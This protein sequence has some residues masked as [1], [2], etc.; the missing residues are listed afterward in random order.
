VTPRALVPLAAL[1][2][3]ACASAPVATVPIDPEHIPISYGGGGAVHAAFRISPG[4]W[5]DLVELFGSCTDGTSE[6]RAVREAIGRVERI[7]GQQTITWMDKSCNGNGGPT[8]QGQMD[9]IDESSN[10][11]GY[12]RLFEQRGLLRFHRVLRPVWR[13]PRLIDTHRT[14]VI[15]DTADGKR[16]AVDSWFGDNGVPARTQALED[17]TR[18]VPFPSD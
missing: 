6:R 14:A 2:A 9:C 15:Q 4:Q 17:W 18:R 7:A 10:T 16:Y 8:E 1:L 5:S 3:S 13:A 11:D 12:L